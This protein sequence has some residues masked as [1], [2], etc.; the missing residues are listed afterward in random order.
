[1]PL[2]AWFSVEAH[3]AGDDVIDPIGAPSAPPSPAQR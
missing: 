3:R 1:M 2:T